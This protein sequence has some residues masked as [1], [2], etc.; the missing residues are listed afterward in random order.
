MTAGRRG[1]VLVIDDE[2]LM[3]ALVRRTL[4]GHEVTVDSR[5]EN[6]LARILDGARFDVII[7]DVMMPQMTGI[8]FY[9]ALELKCPAQAA[10]VTFFTGGGFS[11]R[12]SEFLSKTPRRVLD[13]PFDP[14]E[15]RALV[16]A[17]VA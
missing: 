12:T 16:D 3:R 5:A 1:Q 2:P 14:H 8:D 13:K 11:G 17:L 4:K 6:A 10:R 9:E 15:L 7:C